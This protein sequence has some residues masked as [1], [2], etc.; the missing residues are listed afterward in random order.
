MTNDSC[1][2]PHVTVATV[3]ERDGRFLLVEE[4][5]HGQVVI[6]QPAGHLEADESLMEAAIRETLEETRWNIEISGVL[7]LS[8]YKSTSNETVYH[9]TTF[10]GKVIG[11]QTNAKLD[12]GIIQP[13]WL[14]PDQIKERRADL[15]SPLVLQAVEQYLAGQ[16]Y[17]LEIVGDY[18]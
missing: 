8:L 7:G 14:T 13:L 17:P 3:V 11:E 16:H 4:M 10:I 1:F 6:N 15:R 5:C 9:R 12:D 2:Q 18:R